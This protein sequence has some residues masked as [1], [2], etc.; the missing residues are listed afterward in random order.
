MNFNIFFSK[1]CFFFNFILFIFRV[2]FEST[3]SC[4][5][6]VLLFCGL[7]HAYSINFYLLL[8][9]NVKNWAH[10]IGYPCAST[11]VNQLSVCFY[12]RC[13]HIYLVEWL[14]L[15]IVGSTVFWRNISCVFSVHAIQLFLTIFALLLFHSLHVIGMNISCHGRYTL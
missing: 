15:W 3:D 13:M 8:S 10:T 1:V 5:A 6:N 7:S 11:S 9:P 14:L 12:L 4:F 2:L